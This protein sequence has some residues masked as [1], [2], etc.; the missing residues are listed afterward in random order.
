MTIKDPLTGLFNRRYMERVIPLE[1]MRAKRAHTTLGGIMVDLDHFKSVNDTFGHDAGDAVL[2]KVG[3]FLNSMFR[4][5]DVVCRFGGEEFFVLMTAGGPEDYCRKAQ[6]VRGGIKA[7]EISWKGRQISPITVSL[8]VAVFPDHAQTV[9]EMIKMA[10]KALYVAK[11]QGRDRV[12][13]ATA[14]LTDS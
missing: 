7:L 2:R 6:E 8:G 14:T 12:V 5:E 1:F 4:M 9:D 11:R 10:D 3:I 13:E